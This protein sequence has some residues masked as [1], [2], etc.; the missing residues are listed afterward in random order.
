MALEASGPEPLEGTAFKG[1]LSLFREHD[2][3]ETGYGLELAN[4]P[5][6]LNTLSGIENAVF[7]T[8]SKEVIQRHDECA[9]GRALPGNFPF[10]SPGAVKYT[11]LDRVRELVES[12]RARHREYI[13][14]YLELYQCIHPIIDTLQFLTQVVK[15]WDDPTSTSVAWLAEFLMVLSLGCFS[16]RRDPEP[17]VELCMAAEACLSKTPFMIRPNISTMR[18]LCLVVVT[19]QVV[20]GT[21]WSFDSCWSL[22]GVIVRLAV[23]LGIHRPQPPPDS[24]PVVFRDWE[25]S[26]ILWTTIL[27]FNIQ[28]AMT[29]GMP[30]C[31]SSEEMLQD[32]G[33]LS[34]S[35]A[36]LDTPASAWHAVIHTSYPVIL[37]VIARVNSDVD[38]PSY[39]EI[40]EY[41]ARVRELKSVMDRVQGHNT[42]LRIALDVFFRRVILVLHRR[43]A[44]EPDAPSQYPVSYWSSLECS[45]ALLV[46][47]RDLCDKDRRVMGLDLM[48]DL[49]MLDFFAAALTASTHLLRKDAPLAVGFAIWPRRTILDTLEACSEIWAEK[50]YRSLCFHSGHRLLKAVVGVLSGMY[51]GQS[52]S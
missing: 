33:T 12:H 14:S 26:Q 6:Q 28:M 41:S 10:N 39:E 27:Y 52:D 31:L 25:S 13:D 29:T 42:T 32:H 45:L 23:C 22:L 24:L 1:E 38:K 16:V 7:L 20:N 46:H 44:L 11:S 47:H 30:S 8:A 34:W 17:T 4:R 35:F 50:E 18:T 15:F 5:S 21:C 48:G 3:A 51:G 36:T 9:A 40:L 49:Y 19:K 37:R 43:H 2:Q